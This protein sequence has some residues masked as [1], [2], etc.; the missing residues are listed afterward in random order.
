MMAYLRRLR[1]LTNHTEKMGG[2]GG[3]N[4]DSHIFNIF[5]L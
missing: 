3:T 1:R 4:A 5:I 2:G